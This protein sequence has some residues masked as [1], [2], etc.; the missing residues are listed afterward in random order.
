MIFLIPIRQHLVNSTKANINLI[1]A[2]SLA[3][4]KPNQQVKNEDVDKLKAIKKILIR[5]LCKLKEI[6]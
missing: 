5:K 2:K 1:V 4:S 6:I 3:L